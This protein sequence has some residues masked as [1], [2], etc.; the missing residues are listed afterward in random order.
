MDTQFVCHLCGEAYDVEPGP[1]G[2]A[3]NCRSCGE[4]GR[5]STPRVPKA[6][7]PP[8][9]LTPQEQNRRERRLLFAVWGTAATILLGVVIVFIVPGWSSRKEQAR[10]F[11]RRRDHLPPGW[12][13]V[14]LDKEAAWK[15]RATCYHGPDPVSFYIDKYGDGERTVAF[16]YTSDGRMGHGTF[17]F[18]DGVITKEQVSN[19]H[20]AVLPWMKARAIEVF[21]VVP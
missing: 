6:P 7:A 3:V 13:D 12:R 19:C 17:F 18:R 16:S 4:L 20:P 11:D 10:E 2:E 21:D 8:H 15:A 1:G 14:A 5:V 9:R